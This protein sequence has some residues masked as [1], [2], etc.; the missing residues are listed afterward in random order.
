MRAKGSI[1]IYLSLILPVMLAL[2]FTLLESARVRGLQV[3]ADRMTQAAAESVFAEYNRPLLEEYDLFLLDAGYGTGSFSAENAAAR[4]M[5]FM[6]ENA[7]AS[8]ET[9]G[10]SLDFFS[11]TV[12]EA[13]IEEYQLVTDDDGAAYYEM[14]CSY[15]KSALP[16]AALR[17]LTAYLTGSAQSETDSEADEIEEALD[18]LSDE[19]SYGEEINSELTEAEIAA[20]EAVTEETKGILETV[21]ELKTQG[22]LALLVEDASDLS[23]LSLSGETLY[24]DRESEEGTQTFLSG[25]GSRLLFQWYLGEK[26]TSFTD[27]A[28]EGHVLAYELEYCYAGKDSD[29]KNLE[30][31]AEAILL[32]REGINY[33][34]LR[35]DSQK[36]SQARIV[37]VAIA[38]IFAVPALITIVENAVLAAWAFLESVKDVQTLLA[39]GKVPAVKTSSTWKTTLSI[40]SV[41]DGSDTGTSSGLTYENY[42]QVLLL[43]RKESKLIERSLNLIECN[44]AS[45]DGNEGFQIDSCIA[46]AGWSVVWSGSPMFLSLTGFLQYGT[47]GYRFASEG[48][49]QYE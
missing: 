3:D 6:A 37:A 42:L 34:Y 17:N 16:A 30:S 36:V 1:T 43:T 46:G 21:S 45:A 18:A 33:A 32:I 7:D 12:Q 25:D 39:G 35:T 2:V 24:S 9:S 27:E 19:S 20:A 14:A 31:A 5:T 26:F 38:G 40:D 11:L 47:D 48:T 15:A 49:F 10:L 8:D 29:L 41:T 13:V 44:V 23:A 28:K 22:I 4:M